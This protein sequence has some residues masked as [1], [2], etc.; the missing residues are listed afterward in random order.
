[1]AL[2]DMRG[3]CFPLCFLCC[4]VLKGVSLMRSSQSADVKSGDGRNGWFDVMLM[5]GFVVFLKGALECN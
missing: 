1:M 4:E 5:V 2:R 3:V